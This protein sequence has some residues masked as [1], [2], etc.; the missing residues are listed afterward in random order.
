[1]RRVGGKCSVAFT[2]VGV[3]VGTGA[4]V[5]G[6][7]CT[8][9]WSAPDPGRVNV[10]KTRL[11]FGEALWEAPTPLETFGLPTV[12]VVQPQGAGC[13]DFGGSGGRTL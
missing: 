6:G 9:S 1:M 5:V 2:G 12:H 3:G 8:S 10:G 13:N 4:G 11:Y 7:G